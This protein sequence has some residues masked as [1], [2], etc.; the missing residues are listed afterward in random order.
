MAMMIMTIVVGVAM[1]MKL[2]ILTAGVIMEILTM[3]IVMVTMTSNHK[4]S[5]SWALLGFIHVSWPAT[6]N[7]EENET[8]ASALILWQVHEGIGWSTYFE[9]DRF[10]L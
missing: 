7:I 2:M 3:I 9:M 10:W 1:M 6:K 8:S 5:H 4:I